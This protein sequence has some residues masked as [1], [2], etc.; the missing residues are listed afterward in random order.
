MTSVF[1]RKTSRRLACGPEEAS[2]ERWRK[3]APLMPALPLKADIAPAVLLV[4]LRGITVMSR[5]SKQQAIPSPRRQWRPV[6]AALT[7][8]SC[9]MEWN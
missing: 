1:Q 2:A 5:C 3:N 7:C 6:K 8:Y 4:R 9:G